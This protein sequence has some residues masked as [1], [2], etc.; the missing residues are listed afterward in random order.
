MRPKCL[1]SLIFGLRRGHYKSVQQLRCEKQL[2]AISHSVSDLINL[3]LSMR[4]P[5]GSEYAIFSQKFKYLPEQ[6]AQ[7]QLRQ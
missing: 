2:R 6:K 7:R 3:L 1:G 5:R 4:A